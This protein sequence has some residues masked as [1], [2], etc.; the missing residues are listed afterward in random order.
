MK[1]LAYRSTSK[2]TKVLHQQIQNN[3]SA[4]PQIQLN[5]VTLESVNH[6]SYLG[7]YLSTRAD[8]DAEIQHC[9]SSVGTG[10]SRLKCRVFEDLDVCRETKILVY[11]AI[12]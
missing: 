12:V 10:F 4:E 7:S 3:P 8:I 5:G 11:K 1:S 2:K 6:F 9:L